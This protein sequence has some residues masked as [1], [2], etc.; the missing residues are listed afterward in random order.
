MFSAIGFAIKI[1]IAAAIVVLLFFGPKSVVAKE[2]IG[3]YSLISIIAATMTIISDKLDSGLIVGSLFVAIAMI[4]YSQFQK[5]GNWNDL[6]QSL[7]PVWMVAVIG[8]CVGA[9]MLLQ[10]VIVTA[11]VYYLM[12]YLPTLMGGGDEEEVSVK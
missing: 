7:A 10:A 3:I 9:G 6:L 1:L 4:S 5:V 8:M 2:R 12:N 11:V